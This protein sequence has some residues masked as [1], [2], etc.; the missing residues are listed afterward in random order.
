[1]EDLN[2]LLVNLFNIT[3]KIPII[4]LANKKDLIDQ[5]QFSEVELKELASRYDAPYYLT[6]AK[7]GENVETA[8]NIIGKLVLKGQGSLD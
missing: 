7:T 5:V 1:M 2:G 8:F 4:F 6:S 3:K